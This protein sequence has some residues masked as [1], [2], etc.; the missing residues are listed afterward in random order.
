M[1]PKKQTSTVA[2]EYLDKD[3]QLKGASEKLERILGFQAGQLEMSG[4]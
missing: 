3:P 4:S 2:S 1:E